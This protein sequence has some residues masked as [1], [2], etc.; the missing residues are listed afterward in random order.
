[1]PYSQPSRA[2]VHVNRPLTNISIAWMQEQTNFVASR[3][4]PLI[5]VAKQSDRYFT[6]DRG[7]FNRD[8]MQLR[9]P[10]TESAGGT[11]R[12]DSTPTYYAPVRAFHRDVPDQIRDNADAPLSPDLEATRFVTQKHLINQEKNWAAAYMGQ[13]IWDNDV[14]PGTKWDAASGKPIKDVR[15]GARTILAATGF[16]PNV[17]VCGRQAYDTL[18]DS[19]DIVDR[20]NRGQTPVGPAMTNRQQLAALFEVDEVLVMDAIENTANEGAAESSAFIGSEDDLLLTYR[21]PSPGIMTPSAGYTFAWTGQGGTNFGSVIKRFR[22]EEI[23]SW[24][25]EIKA[26]YDQKLIASELGYYLYNVTT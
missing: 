12:I 11:Y 10:A 23:E 1:M 26:A 4:F 7:D 14:T 16:K 24:R 5:P 21:A 8:E 13:S 19:P 9:A 15:T 25:V 3:V 18:L 20:L 6:Y 17:I 2:D 22:M